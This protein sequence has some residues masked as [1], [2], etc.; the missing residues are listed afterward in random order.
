MEGFTGS[1]SFFYLGAV[2][3]KQSLL[4][5]FLL[6]AIIEFLFVYIPLLVFQCLAFASLIQ[7]NL[8][9][10]SLVS[11]YGFGLLSLVQTTVLFLFLISL[12]FFLSLHSRFFSFDEAGIWSGF[13]QYFSFAVFLILIHLGTMNRFPMAD[14]F[15]PVSL[16]NFSIIDGG[17]IVISCIFLLVWIANMLKNKLDFY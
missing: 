10:I 9:Q 4:Y 2:P 16:F 17:L 1:T 15:S 8:L 13:F 12:V 6:T 11:V 14:V 3:E 5:S 7:Q